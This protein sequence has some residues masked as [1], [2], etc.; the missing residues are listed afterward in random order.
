[1]INRDSPGFY[2]EGDTGELQN[3]DVAIRRSLQPA[4]T[5]GANLREERGSLKRPERA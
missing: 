5:D 1:M 2:D 4:Q 3:M